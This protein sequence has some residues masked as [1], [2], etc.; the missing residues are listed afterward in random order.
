MVPCDILGNMLRSSN[1]YFG[2]AK[3]IDEINNSSIS[4]DQGKTEANYMILQNMMVN[5]IKRVSIDSDDT[6]TEFPR[7]SLLRDSFI[8]NFKTAISYQLLY[9][10]IK[11]LLPT[12]NNL[13]IFDDVIENIKRAIKTHSIIYLIINI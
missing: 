13:Q 5:L 8:D 7:L 6:Y 9:L 1:Y 12:N 11:A 3:F 2:L 10:K 4:S